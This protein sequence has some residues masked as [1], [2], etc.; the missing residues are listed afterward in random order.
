L[1]SNSHVKRVFSLLIIAVIIAF[2]V[3]QVVTPIHG[4]RSAAIAEGLKD[5]L[6]QQQVYQSQKTCGPCH[7]VC[8]IHEKDVHYAVEKAVKNNPGR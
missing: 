2:A 3:R 7:D 8:D 1:K 4:E 6:S 5:I